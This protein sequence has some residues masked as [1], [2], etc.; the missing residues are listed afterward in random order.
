MGIDEIPSFERI[1]YDFRAISIPIGIGERQRER[2][3]VAMRASGGRA[4]RVTGR[5]ERSY[6]RSR[7]WQCSVR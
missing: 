7:H 2:E 3:R 4:S 5:T 6:P 1:R